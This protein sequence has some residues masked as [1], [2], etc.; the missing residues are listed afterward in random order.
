M[1]F[2]TAVSRYVPIHNRKEHECVGHWNQNVN[3]KNTHFT[4]AGILY[5]Y[6]LFVGELLRFFLPSLRLNLFLFR[7]LRLQ[8]IFLSVS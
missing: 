5:S 8:I 2:G 4:S 3:Q 1:H 6:Q 7:R